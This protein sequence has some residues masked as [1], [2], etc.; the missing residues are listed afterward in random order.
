MDG[1][2]GVEHPSKKTM[3]TGFAGK[4]NCKMFPAAMLPHLVGSGTKKGKLDD[5]RLSTR[6]MVCQFRHKLNIHKKVV[7]PECYS[8]KGRNQALDSGSYVNSYLPEHRKWDP[9]GG[10][11]VAKGK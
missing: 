2:E 9:C 3:I 5:L 6:T 1:S 8:I 11:V 10:G 7:N 4:T